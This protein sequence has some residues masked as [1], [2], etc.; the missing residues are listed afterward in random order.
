MSTARDY[1]VIWLRD[2]HAAEEQAHLMLKRTARQID[3][4]MP[5]T[6]GLGSHGEKSAEQAKR[7]E[8]ALEQLGESPS[9][10]KTLTGQIAALGQSLSGY[11][12]D[13]EPV[14]AALAVA[15]FAH[16]EVASYRLL[17]TAAEAAGE[18]AIASMCEALLAEETEFAQWVDEQVPEVA[19]RYL[20]LTTAPVPTGG[21]LPTG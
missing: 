8:A 16:M 2:A 6:A 1:L 19:R 9:L 11:V 14:K 5:F 4:Y 17:V 10:L 7:L 18:P 20:S 12:V 15:A 21:G 13:D 3:G